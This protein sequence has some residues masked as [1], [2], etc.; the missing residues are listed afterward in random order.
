MNGADIL[1]VLVME[2]MCCVYDTIKEKTDAGEDFRIIPMDDLLTQAAHLYEKNIK[3]IM[4]DAG[5]PFGA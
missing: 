1:Q 3:E 4:K 2:A 5:L